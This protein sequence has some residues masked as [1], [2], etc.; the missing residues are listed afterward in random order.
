MKIIRRAF[1]FLLFLFLFAALLPAQTAEKTNTKRSYLAF[2]GTYTTKTASKGIY[3][4]RYDANSGKL[5]PIGVAAET[6]DPSWVGI[7][8]NGKFLYAANEAGK[9]SM[10]SAFAI[11]SQSGKL[12]L[13]NQVS[14]LA[15]DPCYLSFDRSGKYVFVANYTSGN[16]VVFPVGADGKLGAA[17]ANIR[18]EGKVGPNKERQDGPHAHWVQASSDNRF[19]FVA[20]QIGRAHV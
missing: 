8:P 6:P 17:T 16:V 10:V 20:D 1:A 14:A 13:L 19:V 12:T 4:F 18:D 7:H 11:D 3:A 5:T 9:N 2:V 15:E